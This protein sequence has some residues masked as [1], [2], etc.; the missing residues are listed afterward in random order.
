MKKEQI[1]AT[2]PIGLTEGMVQ[3]DS[4]RLRQTGTGSGIR[5][6]LGDL[7]QFPD[8]KDLE[9]YANTFKGKDGKEHE[10]ELVKVGFNNK[11]RLIP[12]ASFRRDRN[13][14][15]ASA[16]DYSSKSELCRDLQMCNDDF[17]RFTILA[18]H[19]I[20]V[21]EIYTGRNYRY[22]DNAR[23]DYNAD[24]VKTFTTSAWPIFE[25]MD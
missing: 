22:V 20:R 18:G 25:F 17:E 15:D 8:F 16:Q 5:F 13:G 23:V 3:V 6:H 14:V 10:Y 1:V 9:L 12:V 2:K 24:D 19:T 11:V 7:I 21:K 4:S